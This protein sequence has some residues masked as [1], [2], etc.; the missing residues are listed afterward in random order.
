M[1]THI[2]KN[3]AGE[4]AL[5]MLKKKRRSESSEGDSRGMKASKVQSALPVVKRVSS[6]SVEQL[7]VIFVVNVILKWASRLY[8]R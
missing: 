8:G 7:N 6:Y 4:E 3:H 1:T 5:I 2:N